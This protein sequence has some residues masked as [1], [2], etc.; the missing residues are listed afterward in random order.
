MALLPRHGTMAI[1]SCVCVCACVIFSPSERRPTTRTNRP[2]GE[3]NRSGGTPSRHKNIRNDRWFN[4]FLLPSFS[5]S[6][7]PFCQPRVQISRRRQPCRTHD[8]LFHDPR[9]PQAPQASDKTLKAVH[10]GLLPEDKSVAMG[11]LGECRL[12][13]MHEDIPGALHPV[14]EGVYFDASSVIWGGRRGGTSYGYYRMAIKESAKREDRRHG[15][16][17]VYRI[18]A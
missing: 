12:A 6:A 16:K 5:I 3:D 4:V 8:V 2:L 15:E 1:S 10:N 9:P 7:S 14:E 13:R 18:G 11:L 17:Y